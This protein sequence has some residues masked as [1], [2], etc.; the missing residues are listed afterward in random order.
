MKLED[1]PF[2]VTRP[3]EPK[4]PGLGA[5]RGGPAARRRFVA[6]WIADPL[7]GGINLVTHHALRLLP[8]PWCTRFGGAMAGLARTRFAQRPFALRI[9][10]N[11]SAL[12]P[13][14]AADPDAFRDSHA[15]WWANAGR[16]YAEYSVVGR[17]WHEGRV[18]VAG[19]EHL[20]A[21]QKT[22]RPLVFAGVHLGNWELVFVALQNLPEKPM[23]GTFQ[24][25]PN[26]FANTV[27]HNLRKRY[28]GYVFP[29]GK[30]SAM[31]IVRILKSGAANLVMFVD[32]VRGFQIHLPLLGRR[33]PER[34]NAV[35]V[36]KIARVTNAVILPVYMLRLKDSRFRLT[37]LPPFEPEASGDAERDLPRNVTGLNDIFEPVIRANVEQWHMLP[38]LRLPPGA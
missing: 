36:L 4:G 37:I 21:A 10:A 22:G 9:A 20:D 17:L 25:E 15:R 5:L 19:M 30:R 32:E 6:H 18:E 7:Q 31:H 38:E 26:R 8:S 34:G 11:L 24:P 29:P 16:A 23:C 13:D 3:L 28:G 1:I 12:R 27:V 14:L 2:D 33:P 35:N